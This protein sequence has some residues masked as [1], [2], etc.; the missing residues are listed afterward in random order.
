[1]VSLLSQLCCI[2][3]FPSSYK[4]TWFE[5]PG[6]CRISQWASVLFHLFLPQ[7][8][9][10]KLLSILSSSSIRSLAMTVL[11]HVPLQ[12]SEVVCLCCKPKNVLKGMYE[13]SWLHY[14]KC[15]MFPFLSRGVLVSHSPS[16]CRIICLLMFTK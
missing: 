9:P 10:L 16:A 13:I 8:C 7:W 2:E 4:Y 11:G 15:L 3:T 1:M 5:V 14:A 6:F 12:T